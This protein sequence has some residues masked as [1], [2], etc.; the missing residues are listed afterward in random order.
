MMKLSDYVAEFVADLGVE[1]F[2]L[3]PGGGCMHL[4]DSAGRNPRLKAVSCLHEQACA[5]AAEGYAEYKNGLGVALVTTGP[6]GTN[7]VTGVAAAWIES[8][9]CLILSG[10]AKRADLIGNR[11]VRSMGQQEVDIISMVRS[12]TKYAVTILDPHSIRY[13]LEKAAYLAQHGRRGPVWLDIPLDVQSAIIDENTLI[14]FDPAELKSSPAT[15]SVDE[16]ALRTLELIRY[17]ERPVIMAGN[18]VRTSGAAAAFHELIELLQVPVLA[19]WKAA[20]LL[21][22]RHPLHAGRPGSIGQRAA[23]FVQQNSDVLLIIGA[24]LDLPQTAFN[25]ANF[26]PRARKIMV[27]IDPAE[28]GKMQMPIEIPV[29]ADAADFIQALLTLAKSNGRKSG[30]AWLQQCQDWRKQYPV[31]LPEHWT[32]PKDYVSTYALMDALSDETNGKDVMVPGSSGP[33]SD[34]FM[35]AFRV[36][37]GQRVCNAPGLGAMGTGLPGAIGVCLASGRKRTICV[38][39]DGGFQLNIQELETVRRLNL[40]IKFFVLD[41]GGYACIQAMQRSHFEGR[42]VGS[43]PSSGLT[44]PDV[45]RIAEAYG[46]STAR[47][48]GQTDLRGQIRAVLQREGPVV[49]VV[50]TSPAEKTMPRVT[51][52]LQKDGSLVSNPMED[53]WPFLDREELSANMLAVPLEA[54]VTH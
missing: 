16:A 34:I 20:D 6:G 2:F 12:I 8:A 26:A 25:H 37:E 41:N 18:G 38:N 3:L 51:S 13:H 9:A 14:A 27:D 1:H 42:L 22:D 50:K 7:A 43:D 52:V 29:V 40:P 44:L 49:C 47:I 4:T 11:G 10:Q 21:P 53:M 30:G 24:R 36:R 17:A 46:L 45:G 48:A 23:N 33:C 35:Q 54:A 28:I 31:V 15:S 19:T 32:D 5:F 39:G